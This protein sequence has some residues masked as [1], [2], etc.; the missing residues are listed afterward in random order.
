MLKNIAR[1]PLQK[2]LL[3]ITVVVSIILQYPQPQLDLSYYT[4]LASD[5]TGSTSNAA[6]QNAPLDGLHIVITGATSGLGLSLTKK[7]YNLGGTIIA[8]GRSQ[9]KLAKLVED[10]NENNKYQKRKRIIPV[11]ADF[12]DLD[13]VSLAAN[14]I[15]SKFKK[16]DY[17][18]NNAGM[19]YQTFG[20]ER[21]TPQGYD[22]VFGVNYLSHF[23]L[24]DKL[25]PSL[26]RSKLVNGS[27]IIQIA[28]S[29]HL[30]VNGDEEA[31]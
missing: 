21:S 9:S 20:I 28:S 27:R 10:L 12:Q 23:L 15:K 19:M 11:L 17:L 8:V 29:M 24:T 30:M 16:I 14:E 5:Y 13:S 7:L 31:I 18:V 1:S 4:S 3:A 22:E 6:E 25:L 2:A 26:K